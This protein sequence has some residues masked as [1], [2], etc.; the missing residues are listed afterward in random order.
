MIK[1]KLKKLKKKLTKKKIQSTRLTHEICALH[2]E[3]EITS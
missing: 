1:L 3:I 2:Y